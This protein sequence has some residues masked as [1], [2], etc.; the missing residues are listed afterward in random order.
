MAGMGMAL[1]VSGLEKLTRRHAV[2]LS[3]PAGVSVEE[4][5]LAVGE[6][7]GHGSVK[8]ASRMNRTVVVFALKKPI[9]WWWL[10]WSLMVH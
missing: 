8:S 6:I 5:V 4:C 3:P 2:K 1:G 7:V 9:N 10:G